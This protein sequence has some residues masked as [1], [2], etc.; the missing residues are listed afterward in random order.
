MEKNLENS[1]KKKN[2]YQLLAF[3]LYHSCQAK[4]IFC[5]VAIRKDFQPHVCCITYIQVT[6]TLYLCILNVQIIILRV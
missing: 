6:N 3:S 4:N 5:I 1:K 2:P